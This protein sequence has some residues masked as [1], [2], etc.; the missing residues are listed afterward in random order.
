[1]EKWNTEI[2]TRLDKKLEGA[3]QRD[4]RFFRIEEFKRNIERVEKFSSSCPYC[5]KQQMYISEIANKIDEAVN[6]PGKARRDY[7]KLISQLASHMQKEHGYY[8][9]FY[10]TYL[11]SFLGIVAGMVTGYLLMKVLPQ[12]NW[13]L[14]SFGFVA[15]LIIGYAWGSQKDSTIRSSKKLM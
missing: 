2:K 14:L 6:I 12:Y 4:I 13:A 10:Y 5:K 7:D 1:M 11:Y 9:P 15:G 8:A 3:K